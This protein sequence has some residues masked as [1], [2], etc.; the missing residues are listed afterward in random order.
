MVYAAPEDL[1]VYVIT[2]YAIQVGPTLFVL[3]EDGDIG[4]SGDLADHT[5][6]SIVS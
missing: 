5:S 1:T 3:S 6:Q 4:D 2:I